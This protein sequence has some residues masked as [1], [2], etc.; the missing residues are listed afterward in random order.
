MPITMKKSVAINE[1][2][3]VVLDDYPLDQLALLVT[4]MHEADDAIAYFTDWLDLG[5]KVDELIRECDVDVDEIIDD[6]M[7]EKRRL[8]DEAAQEERDQY[9]D[10]NGLQ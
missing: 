4:W 9:L 1:F 8:A 2:I 3:A 5:V 6:V 10:M 7:A